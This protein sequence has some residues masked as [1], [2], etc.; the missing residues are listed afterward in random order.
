MNEVRNKATYIS[1]KYTIQIESLQFK[2]NK[3]LPTL[4]KEIPDILNE[5]LSYTNKQHQSISNLKQHSSNENRNQ[6]NIVIANK[7]RTLTNLSPLVTNTN[8]T[9]GN[10]HISQ[11]TPENN[12]YSGNGNSSHHTYQG[13]QNRRHNY[14][15]APFRTPHT[16]CS[17]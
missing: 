4:E 17:H 6:Y 15:T 11:S 9:C 3:F 16:Y 12:T 7:I 14:H 13:W 8:G 10:E 1:N 2:W 5:V